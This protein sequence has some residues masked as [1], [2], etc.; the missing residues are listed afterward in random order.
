MKP[1]QRST[2]PGE[3]RAVMLPEVLTVLDPKPGQVVVDCTVGWAGHA[4]ELLR[5]VGPK[6]RLLG[7]DFDPDNL[8]RARERLEGVG[9]P[10]TLHHG[11]F[12]GLPAILAAAGLEAVDLLVADLGMSS[13][14]VDD[15]ERGFSY[16][17]DGPLDMRMDRSRGRTAAELLAD[18]AGKDLAEALATLGD[19]PRAVRIAAA[20]VS[21]RQ[22]QP[23]ERT[24]QLARVILDATAQARQGKP[25]RLHPAR[26]KWDLHPAAR[27]F[28]ALRILVNREL[29]N[30]Q[31]L[32]RG[33]P[34]CLRPGARAALITFHSGED[35][36]VKA[37]FRDGLRAGVYRRG[38]D[39]P[40][41][42]S[43]EERFENPRSRSAKLRWVERT[44]S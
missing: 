7:I 27:T 23:L 44:C 40:L 16:V 25:W 20:I 8:P 36:L 9:F 5:R 11:N 24:G 21:A 22:K 31:A 34:S 32:L 26:G 15:A 1:R 43:P 41:R 33:L 38:S 14:Q 10:F 35:R 28:Q 19:E 17:R 42:A 37:A 13:M 6:G 18:I 30:L 4:V 12:A 3:H 39:E 2:P 29:A